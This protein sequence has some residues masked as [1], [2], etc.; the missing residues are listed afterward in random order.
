MLSQE[1]LIQ[2]YI[3]IPQGS[4]DPN[5]RAEPMIREKGTPVWV[6]VSYYQTH[7][8]VPYTAGAF[9]LTEEEVHAALAY[10]KHHQEEIE[11][12]LEQ[13]SRDAA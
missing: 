2:R 4:L 3:E 8:S 11:S 7:N 5:V 1:E 9:A 10:Y 13:I 6:V 12:R